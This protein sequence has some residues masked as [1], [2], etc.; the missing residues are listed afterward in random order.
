MET[1]LSS[2]PADAIRVVTFDV[3]DTLIRAR[4]S[5]G[6]VYAGVCARHGIDLDVDLCNR[7]F[8][9]AWKDRS[10][11]RPA[12]RDRFSGADRG[13]EGYWEDLVRDVMTS[14]GL[15]TQSIPAIG[16]F[17]EAFAS[18][19]S[20]AVFEEVD[21]SLTRLAALGYDLAVVSNWDSHLPTLLGRLD[22]GRHFKRVFA[23][24][25][26]GVEKPHA[27][28]FE[29]VSEELEAAPE[30]ILHVGDRLRE[31][32]EGARAAGMAA[33]WLDRHG[34]GREAG[35]RVEPAHVIHDLSEIERWLGD[36]S[37]QAGP[38]GREA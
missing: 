24:A 7:A 18:P 35:S 3:G 6:H 36:G 30:E 20:W 27:R 29:L 12:G 15:A 16:A 10:V 14:C 31:D 23:S 25:L 34:H 28:F 26:A 21:A 5:V 9:R 8:E 1:S 33:L 19:G 2:R 17:R 22:L 13:E 37:T 38:E 32:Y 11:R 4:P